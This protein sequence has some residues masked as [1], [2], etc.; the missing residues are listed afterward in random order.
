MQRRI[1]TGV[2]RFDEERSGKSTAK[3]DKD[4][5]QALKGLKGITYIDMNNKMCNKSGKCLTFNKHGGLYN[6]GQH[7]SYFG[8]QMF[9]EDIIAAM[10][11]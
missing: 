6:N 7:L 4:V 1:T 8:V 10:K 11:E 9:I 5:K 2:L 3:I